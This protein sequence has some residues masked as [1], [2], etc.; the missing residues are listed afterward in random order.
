MTLKIHVLS[1]G[2]VAAVHLLGVSTS[3]NAQVTLQDMQDLRREMEAMRAGYEARIRALE[4]QLGNQTPEGAP[5][6]DGL[7]DALSEL[8]ETLAGDPGAKLGNMGQTSGFDNAYNPA[9]ALTL[10][11]SSAATTLDSSYEDF[12]QHRLRV[13]E[14]AVAADIDPFTFAYGVL[15]FGVEEAGVSELAAVMSLDRFF[16]ESEFRI[17]GGRFFAD[18]DPLNPKHEHEYAFIHQPAVKVAFF[19]GN[20][21]GDGFELHDW[22]QIGDVPV[23]F[24][25]GMLSNVEGETHT[26][27]A[28]GHH[29]EEVEPFGRR[30]FKN[31]SYTARIQADLELAESAVLT[32]G[33]SIIYSPQVREFEEDPVTMAIDRFD[34]RTVVESVDWSYRNQLSESELLEVTN[35]FFFSQGRFFDEAAGRFFHNNAW[36][37]YAFVTYAP[38]TEWTFGAAFDFTLDQ[39][40]S[41]RELT[42]YSVFGTWHLSPQN[43]IRLQVQHTNTDRYP[44]AR[45]AQDHTTLFLQWTVDLGSH[46]HGIDW[47]GPAGG[48]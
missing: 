1:C 12:N 30:D 2:L 14:I 10:D 46:S 18:L 15:E 27:G 9:F 11:F 47:V 31:F 16:S 5:R 22:E 37:T 21:V 19:G 7:Q 6:S 3:L 25:L 33:G 23:R 44:E 40:V 41:S 34:S 35:A 8:E 32:V 13:G 45:F 48:R 4:Q 28:P 38:N 29:E 24:S 42:Q 36:G 17:R 20:V 39:R 43:R 26:E